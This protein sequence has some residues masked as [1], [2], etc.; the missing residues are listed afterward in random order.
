M[1][2]VGER[3]TEPDSGS[4]LFPTEGVIVIE[5]AFVDVQVRVTDCPGV[6]LELLTVTVTVGICEEFVL[7][8]EFV[9]HVTTLTRTTEI[10]RNQRRRESQEFTVI[11]LK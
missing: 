6:M 9:P 1:F 3:E 8:E 7:L 5:V 10:P 2:A 4:G 11:P